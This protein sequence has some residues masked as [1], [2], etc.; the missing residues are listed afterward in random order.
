MKTSYALRRPVV[1]AYLVRERDRRR[2]RELALVFAVA[3][4][5]ATILLIYTG[6]QVGVLEAGYQITQL[7]DELYELEQAERRLRLEA[8]QL[9]RAA[10]IEK[11][12]STELGM[13]A[14]EVE[15]MV[16]VGEEP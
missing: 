3:I 15:Q 16:F 10:R 12:A 1:N 5:M 13:I 14:P 7:E 6:I 8:S 2:W 11:V 9:T 4:P